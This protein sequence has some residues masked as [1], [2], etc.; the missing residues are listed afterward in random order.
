MTILSDPVSYSPLL[1]TPPSP[2][3]PIYHQPSRVENVFITSF[4]NFSGGFGIVFSTYNF[5]GEGEEGVGLYYVA[6]LLL[7]QTTI[8]NST[9]ELFL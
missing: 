7:D 6:R 8:F 4:V 2:L 3:I 5:L 1:L 9:P